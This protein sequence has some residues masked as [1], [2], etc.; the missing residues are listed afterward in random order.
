MAQADSLPAA[1]VQAAIGA[2]L[3]AL[4]GNRHQK[5]KGRAQV[6]AWQRRAAAAQEHAVAT[7]FAALLALLDGRDAALPAAHPHAA[8]LDTLQA[9]LAYL[10]SASWTDKQRLLQARQA[11]LC[12]PQVE[13]LLTRLM[14]EAAAAGD[15]HVYETLALHRA[16]LRDAC[17]RPALPLSGAVLGRLAAA[18][19]A[20]RD[21]RPVY[22]PYVATLAV[23]APDPDLRT[24]LMLLQRAILNDDLTLLEEQLQ[25]PYHELWQQLRHAVERATVS[26]A[27]LDDLVDN[28]AAS[29]DPAT[30]PREEGRDE[31]CAR[32]RRLRRRARRWGNRQLFALV[33]AALSLLE[34]GGDPAGLAPAVDGLY[35]QAWQSLL[36]RAGNE[37]R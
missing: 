37:E 12:R 6:A 3:V 10:R 7:F 18:V 30:A 34:A 31:W 2:T 29:L 14:H 26:P 1:Q 33:E 21:E 8:A 27:L 16:V 15:A 28:T 22:L 13:G 5:E 36:H 24:F 20:P 25:E 9:L 35:A 4:I 23:R 17:A 19:V 32:L 11:L